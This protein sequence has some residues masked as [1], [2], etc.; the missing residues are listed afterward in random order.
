MKRHPQSTCIAVTALLLAFS[1]TSRADGAR[2]SAEIIVPEDSQW[3]YDNWGFAPAVKV[4]DVVY[5]SGVVSVLE[6][7]GSY[8][9]QYAAGFKSALEHLATVLK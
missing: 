3:L 4:G 8:E 7:E 9:E 1:L 5:A 6:G 2:Q